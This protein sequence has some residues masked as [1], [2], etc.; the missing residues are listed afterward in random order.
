[1]TELSSL[2]SITFPVKVATNLQNYFYM[3]LVTIC[4]LLSILITLHDV[5]GLMP[6]LMCLISQEKVLNLSFC[7]G[8]V[9]YHV[10][11]KEKLDKLASSFLL[12]ELF[13]S[14][15]HLRQLISQTV[16]LVKGICDIFCGSE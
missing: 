3:V 2:Q 8:N 14:I 1:M 13:F 10:T 16:C 12:G 7:T 5:V 11:P 4:L 6:C 9:A 15:E